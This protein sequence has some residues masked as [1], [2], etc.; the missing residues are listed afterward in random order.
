MQ[1]FSIKYSQTE[2]NNTLHHDQVSF[3]PVMQGWLNIS[4]SISIIQYIKG[5]N[6]NKRQ[7]KMIE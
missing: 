2:F 6:Q 5:K 7:N 3:I 1:K 4:K